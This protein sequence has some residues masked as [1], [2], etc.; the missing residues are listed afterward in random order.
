MPSVWLKRIRSTSC[1]HPA[2]IWAASGGSRASS[3]LAIADSVG[4]SR[5]FGPAREGEAPSGP[6]SV[7]GA[8][9]VLPAGLGGS[10]ANEFL[11]S[12]DTKPSFPALAARAWR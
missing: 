7:L 10:M 12:L 9:G 8:G 6:P 1:A 3:S 11:Q 4:D 2:Y 5:R